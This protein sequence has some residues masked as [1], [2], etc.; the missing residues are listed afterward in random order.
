MKLCAIQTPY[1]HTIAEADSAVQ[2]AIDALKQCDSS[3]DLILLPE[4]ANAPTVFPEGECIPYARTHTEV[5]IRTAIETAR[6]CHAVVAVNYAADIQGSWRNTT[7]VFAPDGS[8][9]GD[10]YKQHLPHGEVHVKKMDDAYTFEAH[11]PAMVEVNGIRLAFLT[12]Y[13]SYFEEY[14]S[15]IAVENPDILLVSSH[16]RSER[17]D[18]TEMLTRF[19][20]FRTNAFVL[21][22]S[23]S[24]GP[25]QPLGG[26]SMIASPD[27]RILASFHQETGHLC[28]EIG[29]PHSKYMRSNGFGNPEIRNDRFMEQGRTPWC[30]RPCGSGIV[31]SDDQIPY[32]RLCAH[33]GFHSAA[34]ENSLPAFASAISL[35]AKEIELDVWMT[36]D[37]VPVV[38]HD[39]SL[40]RVSNGSGRISEKSCAELMKLDFSGGN[41]LYAGLRIPLFEEVLR[42]FSCRTILNLHI[43]SP[44]M[45]SGCAY[46]EESFRKLAEMIHRY[47]A[48]KHLYLVGRG[49]VMATALRI[50]PHLKRCMGVGDAPERAV[51][52]A[53][54]WKC[55][56]VQLMKPWVNEDMIC[57]AH[58][59]NL[60]CNLFW[61]D[62][63]E[64]AS[65]LFKMGI[66]T[67]LTN[68]YLKLSSA[69]R[70]Q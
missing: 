56:K 1:P 45:S 60:R 7:R 38:C 50:A 66:D 31:P 69:L 6:R 52:L 48:E 61:S 54:E 16:Q 14:L 33:R 17:Y 8:I 47:E 24:M 20:A 70:I 13:D 2:Y 37:G 29:D 15:R 43:K 62:D 46:P 34:P 59:N 11:P 30:Y 35:G 41:P 63:P 58:R 4:Y 40:E 22:A 53:L 10:Y 3:M 64:E 18:V 39:E 65:T 26:G 67:V 42:Q 19:Q 36:R 32:P 9:A 27:G 44:G 28:C 55:S 49:D 57:R 51:D 23:V 21:R 68:D 12:C 5:L 25:S